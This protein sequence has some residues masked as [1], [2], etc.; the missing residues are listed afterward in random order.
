MCYALCTSHSHVHFLH[1]ASEFRVCR[2]YPHCACARRISI[3]RLRV[4][5]AYLLL[6]GAFAFCILWIHACAL[7]LHVCSCVARY[8]CHVCLFS[9]ARGAYVSRLCV[10]PA[11]RIFASRSR[12][13]SACRSFRRVQ[14]YSAARK[15]HVTQTLPWLSFFTSNEKSCA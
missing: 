8:A 14:F 13:T 9:F 6:H 4:A 10:V 1:V 7:R 5:F 15:S 2:L 3:L 12:F 11:L